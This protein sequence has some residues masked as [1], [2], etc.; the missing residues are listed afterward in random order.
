MAI[1]KGMYLR[2]AWWWFRFTPAPGEPQLRLPLETE[3]EQVAAVRAMELMQGGRVETKG[4]FMVELEKYLAEGTQFHRLSENTVLVRRA[5]LNRLALDFG[6][7]K[8]SQLNPDVVKRWVEMLRGGEGGKGA[9]AKPGVGGALGPAHA[10][11]TVGRAGAAGRG[12][13]EDGRRGADTVKSYV[14]YL[15]AFCKWLIGKKQMRVDPT[16][17]MKFGKIERRVRKTFVVTEVIAQLIAAAPHDDLRF[18]LFCGFHEGLRRLEIV[19]ARPEWFHLEPKDGARRGRIMVAR[20]ATFSCKDGDERTIPLTLEFQE[21]LRG[22]LAKLPTG[23]KWVLKPEL[24]KRKNRYRYDFRKPFE[25]Y[26]AEQKV[27]CTP[28][29]MRRSFVSNKL[30]EN[31]SLIFKLAKW[32]GDGV[33]VLQKH[34]AH[35]MADDSDIETG[36]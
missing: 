6:I 13:G 2:G 27:D 17:E 20:T 9:K 1:L 28:H 16:V 32:T 34:Y 29:D 19:E 24:K 10:A 8:L 33:A 31:S 25:S 7:T 3:I 4:E 30:I 15:R 14:A 12:R 26:M 21:F 18:I 5:V 35:L 11:G 23:A 22:Y 36:L